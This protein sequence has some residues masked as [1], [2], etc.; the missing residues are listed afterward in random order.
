MGVK[1]LS[2]IKDGKI[3]QRFDEKSAHDSSHVHGAVDFGAPVGTPIYAPEDGFIFGWQ[4]IRPKEAEYWPV[5]PTIHE[6]KDFNFSNYFYD[7]Y[8]GVTFL[9]SVDGERTHLFCHS[10]ANQ[11]FNKIFSKSYKYYVEQREDKRFP[12]TAFYTEKVRVKK[13]DLIGYVGAAGYCIPSG[14]QGAHL[15]WEIHPGINSYHLY[16]DRIDPEKL[17]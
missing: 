10:Y 8:G 6:H 4:S 3:T 15:H 7:M 13:G 14:P 5:R 17:L 9:E 11:I 1:L 2:P 12:L 16:G